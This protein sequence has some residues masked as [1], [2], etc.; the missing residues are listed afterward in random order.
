MLEV[1]A[2]PS[3]EVLQFYKEVFPWVKKVVALTDTQHRLIFKEETP[4]EVL[5][6]FKKLKKEKELSAYC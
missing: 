5:S 3:R 2:M 4:K 1:M 6:L